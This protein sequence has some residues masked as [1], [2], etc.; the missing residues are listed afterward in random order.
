MRLHVYNSCR[1]GQKILTTPYS[2]ATVRGLSERGARLFDRSCAACQ[3]A[4]HVP[5]CTVSVHVTSFRTSSYRKLIIVD[6]NLGIDLARRTGRGN[7]HYC[8]VSCWHLLTRVDFTT[9][10]TDKPM[11]SRHHVYCEYCVHCLSLYQGRKTDSHESS[12]A[13]LK[14]CKNGHVEI[15]EARHSD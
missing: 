15:K 12:Q 7:S 4:H 8:A 10:P 14:P 9:L 3:S 6:S 5:V 13:L 11:K 1:V 2:V